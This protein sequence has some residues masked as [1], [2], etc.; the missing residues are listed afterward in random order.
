MLAKL[1][2]K[3]Y[4]TSKTAAIFDKFQNFKIVKTMKIKRTSISTKANRGDFNPKKIIDQAV[5]KTSWTPKTVRA[6]LTSLLILRF[7][8]KYKEIPISK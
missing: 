4:G 2:H 1:T 3:T 8:T 6:V 7:Q 5:F